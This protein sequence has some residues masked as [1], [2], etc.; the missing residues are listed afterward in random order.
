MGEE[1]YLLKFPAFRSEEWLQENRLMPSV[2]QCLTN[3]LLEPQSLMKYTHVRAYQLK[4]NSVRTEMRNSLFRQALF[5]I[6]NIEVLSL[7]ECKND[8]L[9]KEIIKVERPWR[10]FSFVSNYTGRPLITEEIWKV[11]RCGKEQT[12]RVSWH[13]A[14]PGLCSHLQVRFHKEG[15]DGFYCKVYVTCFSNAIKYIRYHLS[16]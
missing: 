6:Q 12:Y 14:S 16:L 9:L 2:P 10:T 1:N 4:A 3:V 11:D 8:R 13:D 7:G 5:K 15:V